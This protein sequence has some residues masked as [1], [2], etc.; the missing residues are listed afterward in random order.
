MILEQEIK[1]A[2]LRLNAIYAQTDAEAQIRRRAVHYLA[3]T[4]NLAMLPNP[5][6]L[7]PI[8]RAASVSVALT[9]VITLIEALSILQGYS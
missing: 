3:F 4:M 9:K 7:D 5:P 6:G 2:A 8:L 1:A